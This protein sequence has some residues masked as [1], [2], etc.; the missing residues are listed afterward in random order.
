MRR[1]LPSLWLCLLWLLPANASDV[2]WV[3]AR[4]LVLVVTPHWDADHGTLRTFAK[5]GTQW[6]QITSTAVTVGRSGSAWGSGLHSSP[7]SGPSKREGDGR[8]PA[9]VFRIGMA[10]GY[11]DRFPT[12]LRYR[13]MTAS[14]FCI[15]VS[16]SPL[17]NRIVDAKDVGMKAVE[18]STEPM[19]RDLHANGDPRYKLGFVI[20]HN[21]Q[22]VPA[23]GSCIFAHLWRRPGEATAG[24]TAME[25]SVMREILAW[26]REDQQPVFVLL[27]QV[28]YEKLKGQWGLP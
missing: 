16:G 12:G 21:S 27:P 25:E 8:S 9:G 5:T 3:E 18:N 1:S 23:G 26:L 17:Y 28:E 19:R 24:C 13:G 2:T 11:S 7:G 22:A 14:D 6:E 10:F 20:E 4:Q 15:D